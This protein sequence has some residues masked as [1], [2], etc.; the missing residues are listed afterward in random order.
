MNNINL[1]ALLS[2]SILQSIRFAFYF[3]FFKISYATFSIVSSTLLFWS[4]LDRTISF[5][6]L[7]ADF[8]YFL[9][10]ALS[11][12]WSRT[13]AIHMMQ[14]LCEITDLLTGRKMS[15]RNIT[16]ISWIVIWVIK[17]VF[18]WWSQNVAIN[19]LILLMTSQYCRV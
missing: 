11:T 8:N 13:L 9:C 3:C 2:S 7:A 18:N 16:P 10:S 19:Y 17:I 14:P 1:H 15:V 4:S 6:C 12:V 5:T